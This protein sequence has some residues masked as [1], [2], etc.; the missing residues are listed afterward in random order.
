MPS[1]G[2]SGKGS[3]QGLVARRASPFFPAIQM[4][5][6]SRDPDV[7]LCLQLG[8]T[9]CPSTEPQLSF[10]LVRINLLLATKNSK[11]NRHLI[12]PLLSTFPKSTKKEEKK[13]VTKDG[14]EISVFLRCVLAT[15][16]F[17]SN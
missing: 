15:E 2:A 3:P 6:S 9:P 11:S 13:D 5:L 14:R 4:L 12:S 16:P 10:K 8:V 7:Q 17:F 1:P